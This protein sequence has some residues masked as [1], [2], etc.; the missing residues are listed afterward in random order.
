[1]SKGWTKF[2]NYLLERI[3]EFND[4]TLKVLIF[5]LRASFKN[6]CYI[7]QKTISQRI[8]KSRLSVNRALKSLKAMG[9]IEN[10]RYSGRISLYQIKTEGK[11]EETGDEKIAAVV[12]EKNPYQYRRG[13]AVKD[14]VICPYCQF[15]GPIARFP[16]VAHS[17]NG[18]KEFL[19]CENCQKV[20]WILT[21]R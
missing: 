7:S 13:E 17:Q 11:K 3:P 20:F 2:P 1:M 16:Y 19:T 4:T 15:S 18:Q 6:R 10:R 12:R 5:L 9:I 14:F 21:E 8:K